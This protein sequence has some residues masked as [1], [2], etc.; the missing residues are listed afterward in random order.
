MAKYDNLQCL[1]VDNYS[2]GRSLIKKTL[3]EL[4]F[5]CQEASDGEQAM[6]TILQTSLDLII[7]DTNMPN[8][9]GF[10]LLEEIRENEN[11]RD[12]PVI[13]TMIEPLEDLI[14]L[15]K[16]FGMNGYLI[17]PFDVFTISKILDKVI[18]TEGGEAL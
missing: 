15:G 6:A 1:I 2:T 5:S 8:K 11:I 18:K 14:E 4:G 13:L 17:K 16:N 10:E 9:N 12:I 3:N 7:A